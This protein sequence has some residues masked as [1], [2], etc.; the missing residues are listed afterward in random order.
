[1]NKTYR[2]TFASME[3]YILDGEFSARVSGAVRF[4]ND[5]LPVTGDL[6]TAEESGG[7]YLITGIKERSSELRRW[8]ES[9]KR[10]QVLAANATHLMAVMAM[11]SNFSIRRLDRFLV[12]AVSAGITPVVVLTKADIADPVD[13]AVMESDVK[14]ACKD[15]A[16]FAVSA[17]TGDG[18]DGLD[19]YFGQDDIV[20]LAGLSGAGKTTLLNALTGERSATA[21]VRASDDKG[22]HTTTSRQMFRA[23]S[24]YSIID[25]PGI[26]EVGVTENLDAVDS[27][28]EDIAALAAMCRFS[29][30]THTNEPDCAVRDAVGEGTLSEERL[31]SYR[32]VSAEAQVRNVDMERKQ[33]KKQLCKL[34]K[35]YKKIIR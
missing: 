26:R 15:G 30:C 3:I 28:F 31:A 34:L 22:R 5:T 11:D 27:V 35:Q 33:K 6:V 20:C 7:T 32:R 18:M 29:D 10:Y 16:V 8:S 12:L 13:A 24:G 19:A 4:K 9:K 2:I 14:D 1:M 17:L 21:E 23:P 25:T